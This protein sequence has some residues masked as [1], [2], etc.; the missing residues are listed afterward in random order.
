MADD[1]LAVADRQ[2]RDQVTA[3]LARF[4]RREASG[5]GTAAAV[6]LGITELGFGAAVDGLP[7]HDQWQA[8]PALLL[9]RRPKTM[10]RHAGQWALPGGRVDAGESV[11]QA[12]LRE[13]Q[14][15]V[16]LQVG[17]EA[18]LG[19]LD[20]FVTDSGFVMTPLVVW[21]G[22]ARELVLAP[23]EVASAHRIPLAELQ[24]QDAPRLDAIDDSPH[25]V[26]RMP[27]GTDSIATPTAALLFQFA[28][29]CLADRQT[30]VGHYAQPHFAR[31]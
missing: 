29:V 9:T 14:E 20:D 18:V 25:P 19:R 11:L 7:R 31:R 13:L 2:L 17:P 30:R 21:L 5:A 6:I 4:A 24:R 10:R 1:T 26:L 27:I 12:G 8:A 22:T 16:G 23:E 3:R 15:E 28:E